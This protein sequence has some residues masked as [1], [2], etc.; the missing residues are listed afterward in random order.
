[1]NEFKMHWTTDSLT[2]CVCLVVQS[3][4]FFD[5]DA[6]G[7]WLLLEL[8]VDVM[9]T[10]DMVL[11][12]RTGVK[13]KISDLMVL[14]G[15]STYSDNNEHT[16]IEWDTR[17]ISRRYLCGW[18]TLDLLSTVPFDRMLPDNSRNQSWRGLKLLRV[19]KMVRVVRVI[20][21]L[22]RLAERGSGQFDIGDIQ[23]QGRRQ[24]EIISRS[25]P[26]GSLAG[27]ALFQLGFQ[28]SSDETMYAPLVHQEGEGE[29]TGM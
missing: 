9:Y 8:V 18:F 24:L 29:L 11:T 19:I 6:T 3:E 12:F 28:E 10:L 22:S 16:H 5:I 26:A 21:G 14:E 15:R 23:R 27:R 7:V 20:Q 13:V 17:E 25:I 4:L 2:V 1:M